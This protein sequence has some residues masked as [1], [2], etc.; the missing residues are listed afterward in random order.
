MFL[1]G[2]LAR[3]FLEAEPGSESWASRGTLWRGEGDSD[4]STMAAAEGRT[5]LKASEVTGRVSREKRELAIVA[6]SDDRIPRNVALDAVPR[7]AAGSKRSHTDGDAPMASC[8]HLCGTRP[9][10]G[11]C[12]SNRDARSI[13]RCYH[14]VMIAPTLEDSEHLCED[15]CMRFNLVQ[16]GQA[17]N[18]TTSRHDAGL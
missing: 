4:S 9:S 12:A 7:V 10:C 8:H 5:A 14:T 18:G 3:P 15:A 16:R 6:S 2:A 11:I 17:W 1:E 13:L